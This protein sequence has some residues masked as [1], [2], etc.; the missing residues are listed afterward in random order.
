M[1]PEGQAATQPQENQR[2]SEAMEDIAC[3]SSG[4]ML[5]DPQHRYS[6]V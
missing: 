4:G 3:G 1:W 2:G 6:K 5:D